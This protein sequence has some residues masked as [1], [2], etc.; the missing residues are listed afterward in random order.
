MEKKVDEVKEDVDE[1]KGLLRKQNALLERERNEGLLAVAPARYAQEVQRMLQ[2]SSPLFGR[3]NELGEILNNLVSNT[4]SNKSS[5]KKKEKKKKGKKKASYRKKKRRRENPDSSSSSSFNTS[6]SR[7]MPPS[8]LL[9]E[10]AQEVASNSGSSNDD[11]NLPAGSVI[12]VT[13]MAA[14]QKRIS[15]I[16]YC[17]S[18]LIIH[19][20]IICGAEN[21]VDACQRTLLYLPS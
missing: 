6:S 3:V 15:S 9:S 4:E 8:S 18:F 11:S 21:L 19:P 13:V 1:I 17:P 7:G 16:F 5:Q 10:S 2:E 12:I 14:C 20:R